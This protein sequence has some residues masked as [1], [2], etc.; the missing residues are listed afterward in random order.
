MTTLEFQ[1]FVKK[2]GLKQ[3]YIA[4]TVLNTK[5]WVLSQWISGKTVLY[6]YQMKK[7]DE[8]CNEYIKNNIHM[9]AES[10]AEN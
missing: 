2:S 6:P 8:F 5:Q 7:L 4:E 9:Q 3:N 1:D 10:E